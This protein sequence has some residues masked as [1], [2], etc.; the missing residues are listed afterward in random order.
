[1]SNPLFT[2]E[3]LHDDLEGEGVH[4]SDRYGVAPGIAG[5]ILGLALIVFMFALADGFS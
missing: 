1:M 2:P 3:E 5:I 4:G